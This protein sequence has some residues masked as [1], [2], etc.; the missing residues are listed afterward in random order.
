MGPAGRRLGT[1]QNPGRSAVRSGR[2]CS[3]LFA[4][5][6]TP[7]TPA[8]VEKSVVLKL[9]RLKFENTCFLL[10][11]HVTS[12]IHVVTPVYVRRVTSTCNTCKGLTCVTS[13]V[14]CNGQCSLHRCPCVEWNSLQKPH[15]LQA[16]AGTPCITL[17]CNAPRVIR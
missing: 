17:P 3:S 2:C 6:T 14:P 1:S 5:R 4:L 10:G 9:E 11:W 12:C 8:P 13:N 7:T 16:H 15:T